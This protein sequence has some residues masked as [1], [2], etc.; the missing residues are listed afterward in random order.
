VLVSPQVVGSTQQL[1]VLDEVGGHELWRA[2]VSGNAIEVQ[3]VDDRILVSSGDL[4]TLE[5]QQLAKG[6]ALGFSVWVSAGKAL[7]FGPAGAGGS[8][9]AIGVVST[10]DGSRT[11]LG[12]IPTTVGACGWSHR[13]L[14]CPAADGFHAWRFAAG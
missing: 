13:F 10:V 12:Q 5:G 7:T 8:P 1:V 9:I 4:F 11:H 14:V 3:I 6:A 2:P